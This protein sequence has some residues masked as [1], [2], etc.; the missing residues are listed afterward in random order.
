MFI[1]YSKKKNWTGVGVKLPNSSLFRAYTLELI[2][3]YEIVIDSD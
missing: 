3:S 2:N 1:D